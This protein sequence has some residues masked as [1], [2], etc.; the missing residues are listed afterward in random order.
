M[1]E[2]EKRGQTDKKYEE[3]AI[4]LDTFS[5]D[6]NRRYEK[7][8]GKLIAQAVGKT[9]FTLFELVIK[10]GYSIILQDEVNL[11]KDSREEV[12]TIIGRIGYDKL[13]N[14]GTSQLEIII[15]KIIKEREDYFVK[16]FNKTPPISIRLHSLQLIKGIGPKLMQ[17]ILKE[18]EKQPFT[19]FEDI[20]ERVG[21]SNIQNLIKQRILEEIMDP[22]EKHKLFTRQQKD[23][24]EYNK[25]PSFRRRRNNY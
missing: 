10:E 4:I 7:Y 14:I 8:K 5:P 15:N 22:N 20:Q 18:R 2:T 24:R 3:K 13:T 9:W 12:E 23:K 25:R 19:S 16:W 1:S 6:I 21:I 17:S 11:N